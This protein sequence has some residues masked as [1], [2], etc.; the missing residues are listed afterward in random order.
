MRKFESQPV[1]RNTASGGRKMARKYRKTSLCS[2]KKKPE[3]VV[4]DLDS[5]WGD[6]WRWDGGPH[7]HLLSMMEVC[8]SWLLVF[9]RV[10]ELREEVFLDEKGT[11]VV[12]SR[13]TS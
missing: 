4:L 2:F 9:G 1:L 12:D 7:S 10:Y 13:R 5:V 8:C 6:L 3:V 11:L